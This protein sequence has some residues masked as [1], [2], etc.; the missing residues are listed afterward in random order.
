MR[1]QR[2]LQADDQIIRSRRLSSPERKKIWLVVACGAL[3]GCAAKPSPAPPPAPAAGAPEGELRVTLSWSGGVDLDLYVTDP[4]QETVYF[5]NPRSGSGGKLEHDV[6]C[7]PVSNSKAESVSAESIRWEHP[8][9]GKYRVGVDFIDACGSSTG[10][11]SFRI[12]VDVAGTRQ[13]RVA[14]VAKDR[15]EPVIVEIE[16]PAAEKGVP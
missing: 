6:G 3:L 5:A 12:A 15:F 10:E 13:E 7:P 14:K 11:A 8:P 9:P 1:L 4:T 16:V 2:S